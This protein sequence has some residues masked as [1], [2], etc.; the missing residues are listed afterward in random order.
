MQEKEFQIKF[1]WTNSDWETMKKDLK[2]CKGGPKHPGLIETKWKPERSHK[3]DKVK[4]NN[5]KKN[6]E[7]SGKEISAY[8]KDTLG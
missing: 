5:N 2:I 7:K 4:H 6:K 3:K 1:L 8:A